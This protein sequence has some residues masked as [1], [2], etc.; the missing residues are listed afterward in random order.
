MQKI[1][2]SVKFSNWSK[3]ETFFSNRSNNIQIFIKSIFHI[4]ENISA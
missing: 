3:W 1:I 2:I 4:K